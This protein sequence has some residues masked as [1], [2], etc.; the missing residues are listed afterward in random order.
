[1]CLA[2]PSN[3][4]HCSSL[5]QSTCRN[6]SS[7]DPGQ[8]AFHFDQTTSAP[9][10]PSPWDTQPNSA[11]TRDSHQIHGVCRGSTL[12][13]CVSL[14]CAAQWPLATT[15]PTTLPQHSQGGPR[16]RGSPHDT[17]K[18]QVLYALARCN[19]SHLPLDQ[20]SIRPPFQQGRC[21]SNYEQ[22]L[23]THTPSCLATHAPAPHTRQHTPNRQTPALIRV[24]SYRK[25][26]FDT[27]K[28][29]REMAKTVP[30][31]LKGCPTTDFRSET[32]CGT[33]SSTRSQ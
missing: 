4:L 14:K 32:L 33:A 28:S 27:I 21:V 5:L 16:T 9:A 29:K 22:P 31:I 8:N 30:C 12:P 10:G 7:L 23:L 11:A 17:R 2:T 24:R 18:S 15:E 1:M 3:L 26:T 20:S 6:A 25:E 13:A 19:V